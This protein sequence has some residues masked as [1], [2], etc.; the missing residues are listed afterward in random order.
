MTQANEGT[1]SANDIAGRE[2]LS[3]TYDALSRRDTATYHNGVTVDYGFTARGDLTDH[4]LSFPL[5]TNI[6]Y[7]FAYNGVGQLLNKTVSVDTMVWSPDAVGT[8]SY[9]VDH[10]AHQDRLG[11]VAA[12]PD[13]SGAFTEIS[14]LCKRSDRW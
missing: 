1:G 3:L 13:A 4:D 12:V 2:L 8:T 5:S 7:D 10:F 11:S 9:V 14:V 6:L